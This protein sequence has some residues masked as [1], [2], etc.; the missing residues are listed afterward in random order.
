MTSARFALFVLGAQLPAIT[1]SCHGWE[2]N[3][4]PRARRCLQTV[5]V[6]QSQAVSTSRIR[7]T[8]GGAQAFNDA[9]DIRWLKIPTFFPYC[10]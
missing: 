5:T 1:T 6:G 4:G 3:D 8:K 7:L 10:D 2:A 9:L